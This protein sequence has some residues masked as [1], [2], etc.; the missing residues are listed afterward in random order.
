MT[1]DGARALP[2]PFCGKPPKLVGI[3]VECESE[4]TDCVMPGMDYAIEEWNRRTPDPA[5]VRVLEAAKAWNR[6]RNKKTV[7]YINECEKLK[8][9]VEAL[10]GREKNNGNP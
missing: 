7:P 5:T 8:A 10:A 3:Y 9:A 2:C 6:V 1:A 4:I